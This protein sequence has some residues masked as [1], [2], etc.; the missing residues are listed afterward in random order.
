M[1]HIR[2]P[3]NLRSAPTDTSLLTLAY[4]K[5]ALVK[6]HQAGVGS[7]EVTHSGCQ[8]APCSSFD[9]PD[10]LKVRRHLNLCVGRGYSISGQSLCICVTPPVG[11]HSSD[12]EADLWSLGIL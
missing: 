12:L 7:T 9:E 4:A 10:T 6:F 3:V 5:M 1:L 2:T 11:H 8:L